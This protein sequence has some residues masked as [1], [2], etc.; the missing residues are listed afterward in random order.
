[1]KNPVDCSLYYLALKKKAVL[2]GLWRMASWNREQ[3]GTMKLLQNN[4][5]DKRW[6]TAALKNAYALLGK[7]RHGK[8]FSTVKFENN[9]LTMY[10]IRG[11]ILLTSGLPSR[12]SKRNSNPNERYPTSYRSHQSLRGRAWTCA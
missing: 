8:L 7:H 9:C 6:K 4:F 3:V 12:C 2:Q 11:S 10:R 5:Q 1:M